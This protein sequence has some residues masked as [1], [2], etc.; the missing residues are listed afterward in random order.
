MAAVLTSG[1]DAST[2]S[3]IGRSSPAN[4][5]AT[6]GVEKEAVLGAAETGA[7]SVL[8]ILLITTTDNFAGDSIEFFG[9]CS[10]IGA[11]HKKDLRYLVEGK[12]RRS[13]VLLYFGPK[14]YI[15]G[16]VRR[17]GGKV[18]GRTALHQLIEM[19]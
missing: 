9:Q 5:V 12:S 17:R 10:H 19:P 2:V 4:E 16:V 7:D 3:L 11:R 8:W 18:D 15:G 6:G 1:G 13:A 14:R